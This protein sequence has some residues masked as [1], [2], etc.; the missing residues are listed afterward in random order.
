LLRYAKHT[1]MCLDHCKKITI[2]DTHRFDDIADT[3]YDA[4]KI[5][6]I[7]KSISFNSIH[8]KDETESI[9]AEMAQHFQEIDR[10]REE[11]LW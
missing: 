5:G 4:I 3:L 11:R 2:N 10:L 8:Q 1:P 7:D 9:V 6:L